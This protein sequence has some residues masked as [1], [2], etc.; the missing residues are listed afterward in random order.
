MNI[1]LT[2]TYTQARRAA[3][4]IASRIY[5][6]D[7]R[8]SPGWETQETNC[9]LTQSDQRYRAELQESYDAIMQQIVEP[10]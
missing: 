8:R 10:A 5:D 1:R 6:M 2:L 7:S 4:S 3:T 9:K